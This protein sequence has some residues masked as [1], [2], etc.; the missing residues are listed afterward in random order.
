M[1]RQSLSA[2]FLALGCILISAV[3]AQQLDT[4]IYL[5]DTLGSIGNP[6]QI[7]S[8]PLT[9]RVYVINSDDVV[10]FDPAVLEKARVFRGE[11]YLAVFCPGVDK[12]YLVCVGDENAGLT[13]VD[14]RADTFLRHVELP[15]E[16]PLSLAYSRLSN[17]LYVALEE[18]PLVV[19]DPS[20]DTVLR[21]LETVEEPGV[22]VWDSIHDR[23]F[24]GTDDSL[25]AVSCASDSVVARMPLSGEATAFALNPVGHKL[26]CS[27]GSDSIYVIDTD[28]LHMAGSVGVTA[29][30]GLMYNPVNN[31]LYCRSY[32]HIHVVDCDSD[33][34]RARFQLGVP[35]DL[36]F[37]PFTGRVYI[38]CEDARGVAV[39]DNGDSIVGWLP[40]GNPHDFRVLE[41]FPA[42]AELYCAMFEDLI[43]IIDARADTLKSYM[44]YENYQIRGMVFNSGGSKLYLL[45]PYQDVVL[46]LGPDDSIVS[47][48]KFGLRDKDAF[49][50]I[51]PALNRLYI[52][53][54]YYLWVIDCNTDQLLDSLAWTRTGLKEAIM[55]L[56]P[57]LN[58]LYVFPED[59]ASSGRSIRVYD[60]LR[61]ELVKTIDVG[62]E[63]PCAVYHPRSNRIYFGRKGPPVVQVLDPMRD[64]IV[65]TIEAGSS[66]KDGRMVADTDLGLVYF[67]NDRSNMLYTIDVRADTV[68][69]ALELPRD[70]DT[71]IWN[72]RL[73]KLYLSRFSSL[74]G[75]TCV[76]D[77]RADSII[78][79]FP[80]TTVY[81]GL[82][83]IRNDK[84]YLG[85]TSGI[86]VVDCRYDSVIAC[87][88]EMPR[89]RFMAWNPIENRMFMAQ[90]SS[91]LVVYRDDPIG[92]E[93]KPESVLKFGLALVSNPG[94]MRARFQCRIPPG[95]TAALAV[96]DAAGR[97]IGR[98]MVEGKDSPFTITWDGKDTKGR[99]VPAGVYFARL[100]SEARTATVKVVLE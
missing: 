43:A 22:I 42:R 57:G 32:Y 19:F 92:I 2:G 55:V 8:N 74:Y 10:V 93:E 76:F 36:A 88:P 35:S 11:Y 90:R 60:C 84:L 48:I 12:I 75:K 46:V 50:I 63:T 15:S 3:A 65:S 72:Q 23:V 89:P 47:R 4:I 53:D 73:S 1:K 94:R 38:A 31:R 62:E 34:V 18:Y 99:Q 70:M 96:Y 83:N 56:H 26:Y 79:S 91:W 61:N 21:V 14:A 27:D 95:Q 20:G 24:A 51:N 77:C 41:V 16:Y 44:V 25:V 64:S 17:K 58:K 6:T 100:E 59:A 39:I 80:D 9:G 13:V 28:L 52:A 82:M 67:S 97:R 37:S 86:T 71:L 98:Q 5:P 68:L 7:L 40:D 29:V 85:T 66:C 78:G 87:M 49:P 45:C 30:R 69:Q 81:A 54:E 33:T